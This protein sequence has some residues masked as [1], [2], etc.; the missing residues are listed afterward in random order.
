MGQVHFLRHCVVCFFVLSFGW[1][2]GAE[3]ENLRD[4][5]ILKQATE[6]ARV[7]G[8]DYEE[9]IAPIVDQYCT[10]CHNPDDDAGGIDFE[11]LLVASEAVKYPDLWHMAGKTAEMDVMPPP[12]KKSRPNLRER[13]LLI[14]WGQQIGHQWDR[15]VMGYDPGRVTL[16][17]L[18]RNEYNYTIRDLF[19]INIRP[20]DNFPEDSSGEGGFDN[21]ADALFLPSLL[22]E[23]YL[24]A[25]VIIANVIFENDA[26][27]QNFLLGASRDKKGAR[28]VLTYWAPYV[29]RNQVTKEEVNRMVAV[30]SAARKRGKD[31]LEGMRDC[32]QMMLVSPR[33]L[34]RLELPVKGGKTKVKVNDY[35]LANRLSYFLWSSMPD[36]ELF[37]LAEQKQLSDP[38]VLSEQVS[39]MLEDEKSKTLGRHLGGQWLGWEAL[40]GS[41]NPDPKKFKE[42]NFD[43]R[44]DM[45]RESAAFF[46]YLIG[47]NGSIYD[48]LHSDYTF[49]NDRLAK[50][51]GIKGVTGT[52]FR[53]VVLDDPNRGGVLGMGSVL[54]ASSMPLRTSPSLRGSYI[55]ESIL[56]DKPPSPPM[57]VE[58]LPANDRELKTPTIRET[59]ELHRESPDCRACHS[60]IDPLGFGLENFDA[61][62][63]WRTKQNG[64][65]IDS[66]GETPE[67]EKFT[68]PAELKKLLLKR[69]EEFTRQAARKFLS[70]ALGRELTPYDRPV[71]RKIA[72]EVLADEGNIHTL[73]MNVV[74]SEPFLSRQNPVN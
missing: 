49:L 47:E 56:G 29:Y 5:D 59:L 58:Q 18:N 73:I 71:T 12:K 26:R 22:M 35:E 2:L 72:D 45:Y 30:Y 61:I 48:F 69:K 8:F 57:D 13:A 64:G 66:S 32:L 40:R 33:F 20:A 52:E 15:G 41:A 16:R 34:Y 74:S 27:R 17:R 11:A 65:A 21:D 4:S 23:N 68:N 6:M 53:K 70:Y 36:A 1:M 51:Y 44:V 62:G 46:D 38:K 7:G 43:L 42:F 60:L 55:L 28:K 9:H 14:G 50:F 25:A 37:K 31:H 67:G 39:R 63:R 24:E 10:N 54:V 19:K 3:E